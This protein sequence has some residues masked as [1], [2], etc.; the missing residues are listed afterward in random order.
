MKVRG[1]DCSAVPVSFLGL[2]CCPSC[3]LRSLCFPRCH[4]EVVWLQSLL[5]PLVLHWYLEWSH[6]KSAKTQL[7]VFMNRRWVL[8]PCCQVRT[9]WF[10]RSG[11]PP[12][13]RSWLY[14]YV[15]FE[16]VTLDFHCRFI[17]TSRI[18]NNNVNV[19]SVGEQIVHSVPIIQYYG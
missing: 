8:F 1:E 15:M 9:L 5:P 11:Q 10:H 14:Y 19:T 13:R 18:H 3:W 4:T 12:S 6:H 2:Q 17:V 16:Y 7:F